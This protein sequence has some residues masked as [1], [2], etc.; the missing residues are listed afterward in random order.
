MHSE[1][2]RLTGAGIRPLPASLR[3]R[4]LDRARDRAGKRIRL[5]SARYRVTGF[6]DPDSGAWV[7]RNPRNGNYYKQ[8]A[9]KH[10]TKL[11]P[12]V[13]LLARSDVLA[14]EVEIDRGQGP[15]I[16]HM[17]VRGPLR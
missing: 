17:S 10:R 6:R 7:S 1:P 2:G 16:Y 5:K 12:T 15:R 9:G 14:L 11:R 4:L 13:E 8:D 3:E